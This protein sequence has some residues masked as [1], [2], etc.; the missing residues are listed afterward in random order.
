[1]RIWKWK[2]QKRNPLW[3]NDRLQKSV[4]VLWSSLENCVSTAAWCCKNL[5]IFSLQSVDAPM[6]LISC[7]GMQI[8]WSSGS[9]KEEIYAFDEVLSSRRDYCAFMG[10]RST[11]SMLEKVRCTHLKYVG[12]LNFRLSIENIKKNFRLMF[13]TWPRDSSHLFGAEEEK[14]WLETRKRKTRR[15]FIL[16]TELYIYSLY[17]IYL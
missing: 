11:T 8:G 15:R 5:N 17:I 16:S 12:S 6:R 13:P 1:M 2:S 14:N 4:E 7:R 3:E 10:L 9:N